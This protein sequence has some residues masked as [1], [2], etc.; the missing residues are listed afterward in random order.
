MTRR[1]FHLVL[2]MTTVFTLAAALIGARAY[3]DSLRA[4]LLDADCPAPCFLGV[5]P[6]VTTAEAIITSLQHHPWIQQVKVRDYNNYSG[7]ITWDWSAAAPD[8][9]TDEPHYILIEQNLVSSMTVPT[10]ARFGDLWL[11]FGQPDWSTQYRSQ[12]DA[13]QIVNGYHDPAFRVILTLSCGNGLQDLWFAPASFMWA[14]VLP[15]NGEMES[16]SPYALTDCER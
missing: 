10:T 2:P 6:G 11:I 12:G 1:L 9:V 7:W 5:R 3:D 14:I 4:L 8:W 15:E 16:T 13:M